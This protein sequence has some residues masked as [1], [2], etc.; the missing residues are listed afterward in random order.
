M[1]D[2]TLTLALV[3][4]VLVLIFNQQKN[5]YCVGFI[6]SLVLIIQSQLR[7]NIKN[8]KSYNSFRNRATGAPI[9][10]RYFATVRLAMG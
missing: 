7:G 6:R 10:S 8:K 2:V 1:A 4:R 5:H 3:F 9:I